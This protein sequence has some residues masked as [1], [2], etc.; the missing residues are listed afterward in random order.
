MSWK[1][2]GLRTMGTLSYE[3]LIRSVYVEFSV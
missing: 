1:N 3:A 2:L